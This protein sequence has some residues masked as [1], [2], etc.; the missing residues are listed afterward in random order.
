MFLKQALLF[1][2]RLPSQT[3]AACLLTWERNRNSLAGTY[4]GAGYLSHRP[5]CRDNCSRVCGRCR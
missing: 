4:A 1:S 3:L 5:G 2:S